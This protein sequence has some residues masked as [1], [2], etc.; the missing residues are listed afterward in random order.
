VEFHGNLKP[1]VKAGTLIGAA[2]SRLEFDATSG[3]LQS[4]AGS[5]A[6]TAKLRVMG[7]EAAEIIR[8]NNP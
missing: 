8:A 7:F 6:V 2:P 4:A 1:K 3:S 5:G